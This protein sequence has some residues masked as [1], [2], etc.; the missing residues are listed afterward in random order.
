MVG[1]TSQ[2]SSRRSQQR[3]GSGRVGNENRTRNAGNKIQGPMDKHTPRHRLQVW[4]SL[5]YT[6]NQPQV[7]W[8][9]AGLSL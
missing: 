2:G 6:C 9:T 3:S 1:V 4:P 7:F 8:L 5:K